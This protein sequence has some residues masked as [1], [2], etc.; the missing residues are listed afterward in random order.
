[1]TSQ[2]TS[3]FDRER[4][5][6]A[7][8]DRIPS[9]GILHVSE[10]ASTN[11]DLMKM[12][13]T[14]APGWTVLISDRQSAGRG[15]RSRP[16]ASP[17]GGLYVSILL[18]LPRDSSPVTLVPLAAGLALAEGIKRVADEHGETLTIW[19]KWPNDLLTERGK[20]AGI[21]CETALQG[22]RWLVVVG[23]GVNLQ[24][25]GPDIR[26]LV[27]ENTPTSLMEEVDFTWQREELLIAF[28]DCLNSRLDHWATSPARIRDDW[29]AKSGLL[30]KSIR[31]RTS[32]ETVSGIAEGVNDV[33]ALRVRTEKG[34]VELNAA[35]G[36]EVNE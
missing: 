27:K 14:D 10:S 7:L 5:E 9:L 35:E 18:N 4:V 25:L 26:T 29:M 30:G 24:P 20:L 36:I 11:R 28:L 21:L 2:P 16:W 17:E 34:V 12:A 32:G 13:E 1:M 3:G 31:V 19:L 8:R 33:G 22:N 15:R 6:V 23:V